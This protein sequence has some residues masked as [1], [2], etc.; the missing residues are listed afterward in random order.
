MVLLFKLSEPLRQDPRLPSFLSTDVPWRAIGIAAGFVAL[1][2][3][4]QM[5][6]RYLSDRQLQ[7][8]VLSLSSDLKVFADERSREL[9]PEG[10]PNWDE[11]T[12]RLSKFADQTL[13]VYVQRYALR[14][15]QARK[16]FARRGLSDDQL[17]RISEQPK[18]PIVV[19]T[20]GERLE[21]LAKQLR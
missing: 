2:L 4:M 12:H 19:R 16:E 1:L 18:S 15:A 14:V 20:V 7:D 17:E 6:A 8:Q 11:Y 10:Q 9:P 3:G 5:L 21:Y 13:S